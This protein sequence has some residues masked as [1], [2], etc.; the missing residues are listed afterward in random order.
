MAHLCHLVLRQM[1]KR[2]CKDIINLGSITSVFSTPMRQLSMESQGLNRS[3][4]QG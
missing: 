3:Q 1:I 2:K 4:L